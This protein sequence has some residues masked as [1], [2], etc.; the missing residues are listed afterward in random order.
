M[1]TIGNDMSASR[2]KSRDPMLAERLGGLPDAAAF[3]D[4]NLETGT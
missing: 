2:L 3:F 1:T 4:T